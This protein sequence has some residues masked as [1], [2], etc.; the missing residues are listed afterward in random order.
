[1]EKGEGVRHG[2]LRLDREGGEQEEG[3]RRKEEGS[4]AQPL[5]GRRA[6]GC[7]PAS[8]ARSRLQL[9]ERADISP[10]PH[11]L[12]GQL[13][14]GCL[15]RALAVPGPPAAAALAPALSLPFSLSLSPCLSHPPPPPLLVSLS[16]SPSFSLSLS[17]AH[18]CTLALSQLHHHS[19]PPTLHTGIHPRPRTP[20]GWHIPPHIHTGGPGFW[21]PPV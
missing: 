21:G 13:K 4:W 8:R 11:H 15:E 6:E 10:E 14:P 20:S 1:M 16:F 18:T 17:L 12:H 7:W 19:C 3:R 2:A 5:P 9:S